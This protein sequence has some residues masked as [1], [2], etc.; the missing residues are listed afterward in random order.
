MF[1][2]KHLSVK[3]MARKRL[4][5]IFLPYFI[6]FLITSLFTLPIFSNINFQGTRDWDQH[7]FFNEV[8][9]DTI[10]RYNQFPFWNPYASGGR[11]LFANPQVSI[12]RP[13][14]IFPLIF[15]CVVGLKIEIFVMLFIGMI[16]MYLLSIYYKINPIS[17]IL[18]ASLFGISSFFSLHMA[19][20]HTIFLAF[21]LLPFIFLF[22]LKSFEN[23]NYI[24]F[25]AMAFALVIFWAPVQ[26]L[27]IMALFLASYSIFLSLRQMSLK[28]VLY[29]LVILIIAFSFGSVRI[30]PTLDYVLDH[31]RL[32]SSDDVTPLKETY[33]I[34]LEREQ[35][36]SAQYLTDQRYGWHEYGAYV[37]ILP[38][39]LF[40][41]GVFLFWKREMALLIS[42][43]IAFIVSL[44]NFAGW[45]PWKIL[46]MLP[47]FAST[48]V[49]SRFVIFAVFSIAIIVGLSTNFFYQKFAKSVIKKSFFLLL[50]S[51][52]I[53]DL[54][55]VGGK[56][57]L[58]AFP[59]K[60]AEVIRNPDFTQMIDMSP[61]RGRSYSRMYVSFLGNYGTLNAYDPINHTN[62]AT[63]FN[64]PNLTQDKTYHG[65]VYLDGNGKAS[66]KYW[67][68]N[69][70]IVDVGAQN[71]TRL[72]INQNFDENW[73]ANGKKAENF[74]GLLSAPVDASDE[75]VTFYY[76][77]GTF[78]IGALISLISVAAAIIFL[79]RS[80]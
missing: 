18:S 11:P 27:T 57:F 22:F 43:I 35:S 46:H 15:G 34:F 29:A 69:K 68:P 71:S 63:A 74:K 8:P 37:G 32:T 38:L 67:S 75:E 40:L 4:I 47:F 13:T 28:P 45:S 49:P 61:A 2:N 24:I 6:L 53:L 12:F 16:G 62:F 41:A 26:G 10:L 21:L 78:I 3:H 7:C 44:G 14:F 55:L 72:V 9:R 70:L 59:N 1:I 23:I 56:P 76:F 80:R 73:K 54:I 17:G 30:I 52:I 58:H 20:G 50:I 36:L 77:P 31:P 39:V 60:P 5:K 42:G 64:D 65:E 66:Y 79:L 51:L 33:R 48:R 19:V 25:A